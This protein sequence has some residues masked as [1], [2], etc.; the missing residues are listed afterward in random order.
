M[1]RSKFKKVKIKK[2]ENKFDQKNNK[3]KRMSKNLYPIN[4]IHINPKGNI[5][6]ILKNYY[7][8]RKNVIIINQKNQK[9][10]LQIKLK[11]FYFLKKEK[12]RKNKFTDKKY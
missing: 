1:K 5:I 12:G 6:L 10:I 11:T 3:S 8:F 2:T 4:L 9:G 7:Y